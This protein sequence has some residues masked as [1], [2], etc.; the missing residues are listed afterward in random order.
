MHSTRIYEEG[1]HST[2]RACV[3]APL[4]PRYD[5]RADTGGVDRRKADRQRCPWPDVRPALAA[6]QDADRPRGVLHPRPGV[7]SESNERANEGGG[8]S[9]YRG[10]LATWTCEYRA[11]VFGAF[12]DAHWR[13]LRPI[14]IA[15]KRGGTN[16]DRC[17]SVSGSAARTGACSGGPLASA[18]RLSRRALL[19]STF[20]AGKR[21]RASEA[22][23]AHAPRAQH[24]RTGTRPWPVC[25]GSLVVPE[26]VLLSGFAV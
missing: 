1:H 9:H 7:L 8:G 6:V 21:T 12:A 23:R 2:P 19:K 22:P 18:R 17:P 4:F 15:I 13:C 26:V 11:F 14:D 3:R 10:P 25:C 24:A 5:G 20:T 16:G